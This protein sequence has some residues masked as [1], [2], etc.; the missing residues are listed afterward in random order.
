ML[1]IR[2]PYRLLHHAFNQSE[3]SCTSRAAVTADMG[4]LAPSSMGSLSHVLAL[5]TTW[6]HI[7]QHT[8]HA[9]LPA[10]MVS[11]FRVL[12]AACQLNGSSMA[13]CA[14]LGLS[15]GCRW[16]TVA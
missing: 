9:M 8:P 3:H 10:G 13:A 7:S 15:C 11:L 1:R 12:R 16:C 6:V 4:T 14:E 2:C 5:Q